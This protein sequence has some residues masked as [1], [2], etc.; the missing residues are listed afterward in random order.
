MTT[1]PPAS[2]SPFSDESLERIAYGIV[3]DIAAQ[4]PNDR[5]RLG[6]CLWAWLR[7]RKGTLEQAVVNAGCR[8]PLSTG[9]LLH[10]I[11]QRLEEK[12]IRPL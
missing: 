5:N 3:A 10:I 11:R 7:E 2:V 6:Y 1:T 12:G 9:E 4:E 8:T